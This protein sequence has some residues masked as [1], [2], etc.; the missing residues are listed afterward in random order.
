MSQGVIVRPP[1]TKNHPSRTG[2]FDNI[3]RNAKT[4]FSIYTPSH[5][6]RFIN[7]CYRSLL[8]QTFTEWEWVVVLNNGA[9]WEPIVKDDRVR[10]VRCGNKDKGVGFYKEL[11][12]RNCQGEILV[13]LD[14][15]DVLQP[16]ALTALDQCF[17]QTVAQFV[18]SDSA[19]MTEDGK[20]DLTKFAPGNGWTYYNLTTK[21]MAA[22]SFEAHPHNV[23]YIWYAPNHV[24]AFTR[25]LYD[26]VGGYDTAKDILDDQDLMCRM[27]KETSFVHLPECLYL[28]RVHAGNTQKGD[29]LNARIQIETVELYHQHIESNALAWAD[30][31]GLL[32]LDLGA[33]H[34]KPKGYLGVDLRPGDGVDY[35]GNFFDMDV[36][37]DS[38]GVIRAHDFMEHIENKQAFMKWCYDKLCHG[39]M[40]LSQ[41]PSTDGR[42]AWQDPTHV[43]FWNSNSF[44]YY[45]QQQFSDFIDGDVRFQVSNL[46]NWYPSE[47]YRFHNILYV[48]ANLIAVKKETHDFGGALLI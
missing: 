34:G 16:W 45:T 37:N 12:V 43:S 23:S 13:E 11:A 19:Q 31:N 35:V 36:A 44:W 46:K 48:T 42:G 39:G 25:E 8:S 1:A 26:K 15:D 28:Q 27:Y 38:V 3:T 22:R 6:T 17:D 2:T 33:K 29:I 24:R 40:L 32:C 14:H 47:W 20:P 30:R 9:E 21:H 4:R 41:T 18:Y 7:D 5:N 10:I